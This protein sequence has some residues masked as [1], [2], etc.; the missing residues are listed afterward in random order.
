MCEQIGVCHPASS[1]LLAPFYYVFCI[2]IMI[3]MWTTPPLGAIG[4]GGGFQV[5]MCEQIGVCHPANSLLLP[6][7]Y[8]VFCIFIMIHMCTTPSL[9]CHR[10]LVGV[11]RCTCV[12]KSVCVIQPAPCS[13]LLF[14][15]YFVY[16]L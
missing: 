14:I 1:L 16:L 8:Y 6:P 13:L 10:F 12:N 7:F 5:H 2:F 3:H 15:M 4:F 9:R 11:F